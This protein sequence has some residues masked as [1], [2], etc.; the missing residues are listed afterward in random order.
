MAIDLMWAFENE[1][2]PLDFIWSG[3]LS[4]TVGALVAPGA[5]G[6]SYWALEAA[7]CIAS[8]VPGGD[9]LQLNPSKTGRVI[10]LAGEDPEPV[11]LRRIHAIGKHLS[12]AARAAIAKN[13]VLESIMGKGLNI[14]D[15]RHM[16]K[17]LDFCHGARLIVLDTLSRVHHLD[18]NSNGEMAQLVSRLEQ[19][20]YLT[21][22]SVL[23]LH[24]VNKNSARDGQTGQQQAARGASALIDN[25]RW[26]GFVERMT[27]EKAELL[28]D[29]TFDRRPIGNDRRKY[30]L[31]FGSSK[32]NYGEE[33]DER[34]YERQAE[35]VLIPVELVPAKQENA[36]KGRATNVY[37]G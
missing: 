24:H 22:A 1:P 4:G 19:I 15:E 20:A 33:L 8:S 25:A 3:F 16:Q 30:F 36:K 6:K 27:E 12:P 31:R 37:T 28:S 9:I 35:G 13:L 29:R 23:Y 17:I 34:W 2:P 7:M 11:L 26:C 14:M 18:E 32:I 21:G 5:T 10:Y